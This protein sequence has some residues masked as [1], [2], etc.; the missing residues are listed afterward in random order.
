M[1]ETDYPGP[2]KADE[3]KQTDGGAQDGWPITGSGLDPEEL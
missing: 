2:D 1:M 3:I